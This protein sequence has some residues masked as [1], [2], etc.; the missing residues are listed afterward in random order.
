MLLPRKGLRFQDI[1]ILGRNI[2]GLSME[3]CPEIRIS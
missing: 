3:K 1:I 2:F